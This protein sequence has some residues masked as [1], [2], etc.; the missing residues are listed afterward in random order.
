[1]LLQ[2]INKVKVT[3]QGQSEKS[4]FLCY[5]AHT[6]REAGG[7]HLTEMDSCLS[8]FLEFPCAL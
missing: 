2:I 5:G 8:N 7:M 4:T 6:V 1:M 3:H